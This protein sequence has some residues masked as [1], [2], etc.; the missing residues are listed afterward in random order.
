MFDRWRQ[1]S[2]TPIAPIVARYAPGMASHQASGSAAAVAASAASDDSLSPTASTSQITSRPSPSQGFSANSTP[3][4]VATPLPPMNRK[5]TGYRWPRKTASATSAIVVSVYPCAGASHCAST[6]A[7]QPFRPSP[8]S[9]RIAAALRPERSTLV[10]P[11]FF[12]P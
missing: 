4:A 10:A 2:S 9:V 12:E 8:P 7:S 3:A 6:T 1:T 11:G 5:N